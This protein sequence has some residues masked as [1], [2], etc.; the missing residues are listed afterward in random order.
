MSDMTQCTAA[1][2][3][4]CPMHLVLSKTGH[5]CHAGP[6]IQKLRPDTSLAGQRFL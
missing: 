4:L 1:L 3:V 5:I 2:D 6:T